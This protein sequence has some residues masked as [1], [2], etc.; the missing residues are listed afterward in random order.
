M[1]A[2][3][4]AFGQSPVVGF[5]GPELGLQQHARGSVEL[6]VVDIGRYT[7][8]RSIRAESRDGNRLIV[9]GCLR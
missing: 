9:L 7:M 3:M 1:D 2:A 4:G 5:R 8:C 6:N